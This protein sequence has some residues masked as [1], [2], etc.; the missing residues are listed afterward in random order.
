MKIISL[1]AWTGLE[2]AI[3]PTHAAKYSLHWHLFLPGTKLIDILTA[4]SKL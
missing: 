1:D 2:R 4:R 3:L